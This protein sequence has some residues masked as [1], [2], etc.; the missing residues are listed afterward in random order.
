MTEIGG[1]EFKRECHCGP[2]DTETVAGILRLS[3][4]RRTR[5]SGFADSLN[6]VGH[7]LRHLNLSL[8]AGRNKTTRGTVGAYYGI[9][10]CSW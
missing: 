6:D 9:A 5:A 4:T 2:R 3:S 1:G 7:R 10:I 8:L